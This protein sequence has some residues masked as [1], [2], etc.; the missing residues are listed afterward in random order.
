M[1]KTRIQTKEHEIP[2][3]PEHVA[4]EMVS[5]RHRWHGSFEI[6]NSVRS[7]IEFMSC[8]A[9]A[10]RV[11]G[12]VSVMASTCY[13][14]GLVTYRCSALNS[15]GA[16]RRPR[17]LRCRCRHQRIDTDNDPISYAINWGMARPLNPS[18]Q[19]SRLQFARRYG[20]YPVTI[21][22]SDTRGG[23]TYIHLM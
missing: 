16:H 10:V 19:L 9:Q 1:A 20:T 6:A 22:V 11:T 23:K 15:V 5:P 12:L 14:A 13:L 7:S 18:M 17:W 3:I 21:T 2:P 4:R 8:A